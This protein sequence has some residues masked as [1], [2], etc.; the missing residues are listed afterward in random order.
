[1]VTDFEG[2]PKF[3]YTE[4]MDFDKVYEYLELFENIDL[5]EDCQLLQYHNIRCSEECQDDE[6]Y[7]FDDEFF[8]TF[9]YQKPM[10]A[11]RATQFG[12]VNW[13][14]EYIR[15]DGC[16]NLESISNIHDHI[17]RDELILWLLDNPQYI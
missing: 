8:E 11:A 1:M 4:S 6:I 15:F 17:D 12:S 5:D 9:F 2:F 3:L 7:I 16:G 13:G 14:Y 10:E